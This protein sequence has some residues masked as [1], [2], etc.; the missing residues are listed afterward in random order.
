MQGREGKKGYQAGTWAL[1][2][3]KKK[4]GKSGQNGSN[5]QQ[6]R[7]AVCCQNTK[8]LLDAGARQKTDSSKG[9]RE[10]RPGQETRARQ[11]MA[12]GGQTG[13]DSVTWGRLEFGERQTA[14]T[15]TASTLT[16]QN[17]CFFPPRTLF[18]GLAD[19]CATDARPRPLTASLVVLKS[20]YSLA[21]NPVQTRRTHRQTNQ[22]HGP[23]RLD[24]VSVIHFFGFKTRSALARVQ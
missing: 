9:G 17:G 20:S 18:L 24:G 16:M 1:E 2:G 7:A 21:C 12:L 15:T 4:R 10:G 5:D 8:T 11:R 6:A 19:D 13:R 3:R 22:E 14:T 23:A